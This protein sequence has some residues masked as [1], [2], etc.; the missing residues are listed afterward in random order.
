MTK[1][2]PAA[3]PGLDKRR[4]TR[5]VQAMPIK[6]HGMDAL[7]ESFT[8]RTT[9]V[10]VSC[11]GCKYQSK[12]YVPKGSHVTLEIPRRNPNLPVRIVTGVVIWVQRPSQAQDLLHIGLEFEVPGNVWDTPAAPEDWFPLPGEQPYVEEIVEPLPVP[13]AAPAAPVTLTAS[14]D[15]SEILVMAGRAEGHEEEVAAALY[16]AKSAAQVGKAAA[17]EAAIETLSMVRPKPD[18]G[19]HETIEQIVKASIERLSASLAEQARKAYQPTADQLDAKIKQA[20]A[21]AMIKIPVKRLR[22]SKAKP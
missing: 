10:M 1:P 8:E 18:A 9:T 21:E 6:V 11:H 15:A 14:W 3:N 7:S 19:L 5:L 17:A 22:R 4:S 12:H 2:S 20:V 13:V 16:E